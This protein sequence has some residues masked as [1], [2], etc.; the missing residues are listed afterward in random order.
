M[1]A[2]ED[3]AR[4]RDRRETGLLCTGLAAFSFVFWMLF[5]WL[6]GWK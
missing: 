6:T 5:G 4:K 2:D 3:G 1:R